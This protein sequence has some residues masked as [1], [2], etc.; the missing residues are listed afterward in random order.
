MSRTAR[1]TRTK[2]TRI[3]PLACLGA[4]TVVVVPIASSGC[5]GKTTLWGE[6]GA[7]GSSTATSRPT[8]TTT[9]SPPSTGR[10]PR[11]PEDP[12]EDPSGQCPTTSPIDY[13]NLPYS[14]PAV[15]PGACTR[16]EVD[17]L[18][19]FIEKENDPRDWKAS[20][21]SP[22][23][24]SCVFGLYTAT[25]WAPILEDGGGNPLALNV[26][27]CIAIRSGIPACGKAYQQ[28]YDC[29]LEACIDCGDDRDYARCLSSADKGACAK[30]YANVPSSCG[31]QGAV[32]SAESACEMSDALSGLHGAIIAQCADTPDGG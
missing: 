2:K 25:T 15:L 29:R 8:S 12:P 26:G 13:S 21:G 17:N 1:T 7:G 31:G 10:P 23:C 28:W 9:S 30:A 16:A 32:S 4:L 22:S 18:I 20:I 24:R 14:P 19:A 27:G 3:A 11:P 5:G 6:G